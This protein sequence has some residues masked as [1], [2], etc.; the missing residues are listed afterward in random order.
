M[1]PLSPVVFFL[2]AQFCFSQEALWKEMGSPQSPSE[3]EYQRLKDAG[4]LQLLNSPAWIETQRPF[5]VHVAPPGAVPYSPGLVNRQK[6]VDKPR[7]EDK[8]GASKRW[9]TGFPCLRRL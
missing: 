6:A 4:Q 3:S 8:A 2:I 9:L 7:E 5:A 1:R